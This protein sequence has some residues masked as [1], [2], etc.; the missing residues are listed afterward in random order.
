MANVKKGKEGVNDD[1]LVVDE[2]E[3]LS[4]LGLA[5]E[6]GDPSDPEI[7]GVWGTRRL[8]ESKDKILKEDN[9]ELLDRVHLESEIVTMVKI[10]WRTRHN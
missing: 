6:D 3:G 9:P 5:A 7:L 8:V 1:H 10:S 4:W 2:D